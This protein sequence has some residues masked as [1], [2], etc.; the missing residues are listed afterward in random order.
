MDKDQVTKIDRL[1][2]SL[3]N[4]APHRQPHNGDFL[5]P[6]SVNLADVKSHSLSCAK[7][8]N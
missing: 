8:R 5:G 1:L 4:P 6:A 7:S 3:S 2:R